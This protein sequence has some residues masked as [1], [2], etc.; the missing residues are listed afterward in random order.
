MWV[1]DS[2]AWLER[3]GTGWLPTKR[4]CVRAFLCCVFFSLHLLHVKVLVGFF[5]SLQSRIVNV[6]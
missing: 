1:W 3:G 4:W 6:G 2:E 5:S